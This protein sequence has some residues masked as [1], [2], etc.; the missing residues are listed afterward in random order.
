MTYMVSF[1]RVL[2][3]VRFPLP[4]CPEVAHSAGRMREHFMYRNFLSQIEVVQEGGARCPAM[5]CAVCTCQRSVYLN[6]TGRSG[7]N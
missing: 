5:T 4:G 3:T 6:T 7:A 2:K 1:P